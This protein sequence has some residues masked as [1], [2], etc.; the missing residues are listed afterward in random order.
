MPDTPADTIRRAA[1]LM[2][3]R[4]TAVRPGPWHAEP[5][6]ISLPGD[7]P[8]P[9]DYVAPATGV[10]RFKVHSEADAEH[11]AAMHPGVTTA[12][13][14]SWEHQADDMADWEANES[15]AGGLLLPVVRSNKHGTRHDWTATLAAARTYLGETPGRDGARDHG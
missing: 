6:S 13:A 10:P 14:D 2:R 8:W 12:I 5:G 11:I 15:I 9:S 4:A 3:E 1:Q 7:K